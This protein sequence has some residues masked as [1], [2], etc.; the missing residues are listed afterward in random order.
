MEIS[1]QNP[2]TFETVYNYTNIDYSQNVGVNLSKSFSLKSFWKFNLFAAGEY[3]ENYFLG[4]DNILYKNDVFFYNANVS[5]Q[6][7]LDK[8]KTWDLNI[9]YVYNSKTIQGSFDISSSQNTNIIINKKMFNKRLEAGLVFNDIFRT[10][11]NI[12]STRYA[13]QNQYF[14]DYRDTQYF[15][16]NL[17]YNFGNQK[18]K[19]AKSGSKTDEQKRL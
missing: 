10:N 9:S 5:T 14:K 15:M 2:E 17:K 1:I 11:K 7:T 18:V 16:V 4:T 12:I 19:E 6:I 13:D 3:N 8:A